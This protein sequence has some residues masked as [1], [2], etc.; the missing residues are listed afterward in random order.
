MSSS[1]TASMQARRHPDTTHIDRLAT[2]DMLAM[3][4]QDDKQISEAVGACL[5]D[6]ARLIDIATATM[7]RGGRLVIIGAGES[8]RTAVQAVSDYSP[9]GKHALVGL[10]AGGRRRRWPSGR[11]RR[12]ITI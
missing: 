6:I 8:G 5:P 10:I 9:E 1:L 11:P 2:A 3:L 4:H 12:I 7:S